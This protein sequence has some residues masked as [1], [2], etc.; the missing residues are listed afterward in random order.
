MKTSALVCFLLVSDA[1]AQLRATSSARNGVE[2]EEDSVNDNL[3][4]PQRR[5]LKA[6]EVVGGSGTPPASAL[7]L[8]HCQGDC[9][10]DADCDTGLVCF[11]KAEHRR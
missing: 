7:P 2:I 6:I 8:E 11:Q 1:F 3:F 10:T 5:N 4:N 9:D